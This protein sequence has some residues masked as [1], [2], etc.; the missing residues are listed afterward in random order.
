MDEQIKIATKV[1]F[2]EIIKKNSCEL[3]Y[4]HQKYN[5]SPRIIIEALSILKKMI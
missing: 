1:I 2:N 5:L 4:L 3:F